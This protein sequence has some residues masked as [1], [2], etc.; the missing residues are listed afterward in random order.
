[1]R[2]RYGHLWL[3]DLLSVFIITSTLPLLEE[4]EFVFILPL[5]QTILSLSGYVYNNAIS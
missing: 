1:M 2:L 3:N 4:E 5:F